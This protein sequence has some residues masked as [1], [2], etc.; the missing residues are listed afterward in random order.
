M[1]T[2][3]SPAERPSTENPPKELVHDP[4]RRGT[5]R[6]AT[7]DMIRLLVLPSI[8]GVAAFGL[9]ST[10][11]GIVAAAG[12]LAAL[13]WQRRRAIRH[14]GV[15]LHVEDGLLEVRA[16]R[17]SEVR[18]RVRLADLLDVEL[19]TKSERLMH[20]GGSAIPAIAFA[21]SR[22]GDTIER[23]RIVLVRGTSPVPLP[24]SEERGSH[25]E[26]TEQLGKIRV[27]LRK[28]G[29]LPAAE[30]ESAAREEEEDDG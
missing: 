24:L 23:A 19:D 10:T 11:A 3:R 17:G 26:A 12:S 7:V 8:A 25:S 14:G 13:L 28:H 2:Y 18:A 30:R 16:R 6:S 15:V 22:A 4:T 20:E 5:E 9:V 1:S 27:F 21:E 29:W